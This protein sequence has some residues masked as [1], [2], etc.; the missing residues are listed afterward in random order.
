MQL[1]HADAG[2]AVAGQL[3]DDAFELQHGQAAG[4]FFRREL[5][6]VEDLLQIDALDAQSVQNRAFLAA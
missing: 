4:D 3:F 2:E 5:G 6:G 1:P